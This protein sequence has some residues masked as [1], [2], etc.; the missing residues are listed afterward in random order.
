MLND[1]ERELLE[2]IERALLADLRLRRRLESRAHRFRLALAFWSLA[3][4]VVTLATA[5]VGLLVLALPGQAMI[6]LLLAV[7]PLALLRRRIAGRR[8]ARSQAAEDF[9]RDQ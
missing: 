2:E 8:S 9:S 1:R 4:L 6:V 7:W 3:A 5:A